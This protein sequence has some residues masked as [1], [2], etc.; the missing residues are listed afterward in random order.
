M[1][2]SAHDS[3]SGGIAI[4]GMAGRFPGA[5]SIEEYWRNLAAGVESVT[6]F[7][8]RRARRRGHRSR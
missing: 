2:E 1:T 5:E 3:F 8:D 6:L 7:S 4:V